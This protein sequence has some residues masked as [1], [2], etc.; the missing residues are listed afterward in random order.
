MEFNQA[1]INFVILTVVA[2]ALL[3][4][5]LS[6]WLRKRTTF[7]EAIWGVNQWTLALAFA[8]GMICG[9]CFTVPGQP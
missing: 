9:H 4:Y 2:A 1:A 7:S 5:D 8:I 6:L 3:F